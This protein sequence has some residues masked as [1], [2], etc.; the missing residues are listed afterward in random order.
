[1]VSPVRVVPTA[2]SVSRNSDI[3]RNPANLGIIVASQRIA[4]PS[5]FRDSTVLDIESP[6]GPA[7]GWRGVLRD[8]EDGL[9]LPGGITLVDAST[10]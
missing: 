7:F 6:D 10:V 2:F 8:P 1:V 4:T 3:S 5:R 9:P